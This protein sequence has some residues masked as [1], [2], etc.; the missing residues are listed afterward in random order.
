MMLTGNAIKLDDI[1]NFSGYGIIWIL[2]ILVL[3]ATGIVVFFRYKKR[4]INFSGAK[5]SFQTFKSKVNSKIPTRLA[6]EMSHTMH[7]TNKSPESQSLDEYTA[8]KHDASLRDLT[9]PKVIKAEPSLVL[10]GEKTPTTIVAINIKNYGELTPNSIESLKNILSITKDKKG[11]IDFRDEDIFLV[12]S[13]LVTK[14]YNNESIAITAASEVQK[15]LEDHNRKFQNKIKFNIG[16]HRGELIASK[17]K[18]KLKYTSIG[19]TI[20]MAKKLA[21]LEEGKSL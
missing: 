5:E 7:L 21:S 19:N 8:N 11:L 17:E 14:T 1:T 15:K 2:I 10:R 13:P 9:I 12:F 3:I 18:G 16:I 4:K 6:N 20:S